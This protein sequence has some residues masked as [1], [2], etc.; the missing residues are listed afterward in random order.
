[1]AGR[2]LP[3]GFDFDVVVPVPLHPRKRRERGFNQAALLADGIAVGLSVPVDHR[4]LF[5]RRYTA[6]QARLQDDG[7][8]RSNVYG[9]F[10]CAEGGCSGARVL[11]VDDVTTT[12]AT[13]GAAASALFLGGAQAVFGYAFAIAG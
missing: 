1:M 2:Q 9:A 8:R 12:G 13:L 10:E 5:R 7:E 6:T 3:A 11:L 4:M